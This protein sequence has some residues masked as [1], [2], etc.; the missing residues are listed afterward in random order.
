MMGHVRQ[1]VS[2]GIEVV[3]VTPDY[4]LPGGPEGGPEKIP[5]AYRHVALESDLFPV[6]R[7]NMTGKLSFKNL[8]A[9][10]RIIREE[11]PECIHAT[12][13][14]E[15]MIFSAASLITNVPIVIS[16]HTDVGQVATLDP[17]FKK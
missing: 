9:L 5:G 2:R 11:R 8:L 14:P 7:K 17:A 16:M 12:Q 3:V 4:A 1:L 10:V 15:S 6:Y 13:A